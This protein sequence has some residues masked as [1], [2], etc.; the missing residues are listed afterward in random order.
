MVNWVEINEKVELLKWDELLLMAKDYSVFQS[1]LWGEYKRGRHQYPLRYWAKDKNNNVVC[2]IQFVV[3]ENP[4]GLNL[5]WASG[6]PVIMFND[7]YEKHLSV[8]IESLT[9]L[10]SNKFKHYLVRFN[11]LIDD[12]HLISYEINKKCCRPLYKLSSGYTVMMDLKCNAD[13]FRSNMS[14]KHRYYTK[15]ASN[16]F[17]SWEIG[18]STEQVNNFNNIY[19]SM[20]REKGVYDASGGVENIVRLCN[21]LKENVLI[22]VGSMNELPVVSCIVLIFGE[23]S[24]YLYAASNEKGRENNISYTMFERLVM[25]LNARDATIFDFGCIDPES[26]SAAGVDHFKKGFGGRVVKYLGE[27]ECSSSLLSKIVVN[28][29]IKLFK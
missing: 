25:E 8:Y 24:Y 5:L 28:F 29:G 19:T 14:K 26:R 20:I 16:K 12:D 17:V 15:K 21:E 4:L 6:G 23:K 10:L 22:M 9:Q 11:S 1:I 27:W 13:Q 7:K 2:M 18:N 3:K